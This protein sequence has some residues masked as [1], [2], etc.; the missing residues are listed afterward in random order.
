LNERVPTL[1]LLALALQRA[2]DAGGTRDIAVKGIDAIVRVRRPIGH[3]TLEGYSALTAVT[4]S[5]WQKDRHSERWRTGVE[6]C[7][8]VL[9]RYSRTFPI[10]EPRYRLHLGDYRR[11]KGRLS[12]ARHCYE[13]GKAAAEHLGMPSEAR[14]CADAVDA[15]PRS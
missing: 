8:R 4:L 9:R 12:L 1:G 5:E 2:G 15:V 6:E 13:K 10:G 11:I 3:G 14:Y 7:L